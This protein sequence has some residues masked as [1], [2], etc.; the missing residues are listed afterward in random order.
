MGDNE[1]LGLDLDNMPQPDANLRYLE[2]DGGQ[3]KLAADDYLEGAP[4]LIVEIS[5]SSAAIDLHDSLRA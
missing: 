1:S 4:E 3:S 2:T 5:A